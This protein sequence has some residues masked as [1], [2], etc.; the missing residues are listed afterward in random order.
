MLSLVLIPFVSWEHKSSVK[1][2]L[3]LACRV[4]NFTEHEL[5]AESF[6]KCPQ[7]WESWRGPTFGYTRWALGA[8][9]MWEYMR[10]QLKV[11]CKSLTAV[12]QIRCSHICLRSC[13]SFRN[14]CH[15]MLVTVFELLR[16]FQVWILNVSVWERR[17]SVCVCWLWANHLLIMSPWRRGHHAMYGEKGVIRHGSLSHNPGGACSP[18]FPHWKNK[19]F[20][21]LLS[22][23]P[24]VIK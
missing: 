14:A 15:R 9:N 1:D 8:A 13:S 7:N 12:W 6:K 11:T 3:R 5:F 10:G 2:T 17:A 20:L 16:P 24:F 23:I 22:K 18:V 21:C 19:T 4:E